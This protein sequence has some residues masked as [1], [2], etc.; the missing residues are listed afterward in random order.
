M[1][2]LLICP[3]YFDYHDLI[4]RAIALRGYKVDMLTDRPYDSNI[5]KVVYRYGF[6]ALLPIA[7]S[8]YRSAI[9]GFQRAKYKKILVI[10][11]EGVS[12]QTLKM[13]RGCFPQAELIY[14]SWDNLKNKPS[15]IMSNF[16]HYDRVLSFDLADS[17]RF[18]L[19]YRPL[20]FSDGYRK[21]VSNFDS[22]KKQKI[23][24][25]FVGTVHSDR[26]KI[27]KCI[28]KVLG[29]SNRSFFTYLYVQSKWVFYARKLFDINMWGDKISEYQTIPLPTHKLQSVFAQSRTILD[30]EHPRQ[31]GLTMRSIEALAANRKIVTTNRSMFDLD[32]YRPENV[33]VISRASPEKIDTKFFDKPYVPVLSSVMEKYTLDQWVCDVVDSV[34]KYQ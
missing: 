25:S 27:I 26:V 31:T 23:D 28:K 22:D 21:M 19:T 34:H 9:A 5:A 1:N 18:G 32:L 16:R 11:G 17:D 6:G 3:K 10:Q 12:S 29:Q 20:F 15:Y 30:I 2:I 33:H 4:S 7:D 13:L 8:Y 14:Y 24:L